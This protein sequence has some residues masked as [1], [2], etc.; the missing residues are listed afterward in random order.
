MRD[1]IFEDPP[2]TPFVECPNCRRLL[3]YGVK[4]CPDCYEEIRDDYA[5]LSGAVVVINTKA[6]AMANT[7]KTL[8][9]SAA[10]ALGVT[11]FSYLANEPPA[12]VLISVTWP[13]GALL[14]IALWFIRFGRFKLGD[15]DY[16]RARKQM[17][18]RL[19]AWSIFTAVLWGFYFF[20]V[21]SG[22]RA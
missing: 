11:V 4:R 6:C 2:V 18:A 1:S 12:I 19:I 13:V 8:D 9:V 5:L 14:A 7:I 16:A 21:Q 3:T 17:R 22:H 10:I 15:D 20:V